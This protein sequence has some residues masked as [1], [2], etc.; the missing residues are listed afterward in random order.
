MQAPNSQPKKRFKMPSA[1]TILFIIIA[2]VAVLTWIIPAG[3]YATDK[4]GNIIAH[5]Y[6]SVSSNP[7]GI[8]DIFMAP[9][10]GMVGNDHTEGA[11][12]IS[13]FILVIGGFLGVV[14]K[15]KAL[16]DGIGAVVR[17]YKGKEKMLI[18]ILMILFA[19]GGS[20]YGM[21]EETI[22]FYPLLIPVMIGVGFDSLTAVA[23]ILVGSQIGCLASTVNPF[24]T[25][26]ASQTMN[27]SMGEGLLPRLLLLVIAL[28]VGIWYVYRYASKIEKDP[29]KS[30]I[31]EQR[32]EDLDRFAVT[33]SDENVGMTGRQKG[34]LWLF[35]GTFILM[36]VGL[37]PWSTI[38]DKWTFFES[39]TKWLTG[40]PVL[41][42]LFGSDAVPLGDWYFSEITMLFLLMAVVIMFVYKMKETEFINAFMGGMAEFLSVAIIV[43][44]ARG[45]QVVMNDGLIT[46]TVLHWGEMGLKGLSESVFIIITYIFYIPMSFLIP[47]TSGLASA[48]M[49]IIGPM[50]KFAGVDGSVVITAY[51]A[52]SGWV[53]LIT[54]TSG[55]VM[56]ALAIAHIGIGTWWKWIAKLMIYLFITSCIFLGVLAIL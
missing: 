2:L 41:G 30:A 55:V 3:Q 53:N 51:Q 28:A 22:A 23:I 44:V 48:T 46:D 6:K 36:I 35:G 32:Q 7:Q 9:V 47:S 20:T 52:A 50:G 37:I 18:P 12:S 19:L 33:D 4:A 43:A 56:G 11:I 40:I 31:Y 24:A 54:P 5:T 25:G 27:L 8:W 34:V 29:S 1:F 15:T 26:V 13:L 17:K 16:D 21:A 14:N 38:N 42:N 39:A 45:I 10:Y 49:G